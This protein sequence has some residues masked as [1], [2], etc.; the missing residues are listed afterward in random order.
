MR[1]AG[2]TTLAAAPEALRAVLADPERLGELLPNVE[3]FA[4]EDA[5]GGAFAAVIRPALALGEIPV[6]T[7][8]QPRAGD[9]AL[10]YRVEGR[11]DEH[12]VAFDVVLDVSGA[13]A[14]G[15]SLV[16]WEL[17][18]HVTGTLRSAGQ[19]VLVPIVDRQV[20]TV[21][22]AAGEEAAP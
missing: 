21:L 17:D 1:I 15:G 16:A 7:V 2:T 13:T 18:L 19:R 22:A 12:R 4:W 11:T 5:P 8:W 20:R 3:G 6:R 10:R 14:G 9:G